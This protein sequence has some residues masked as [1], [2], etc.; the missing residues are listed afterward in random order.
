M[1]YKLILAPLLRFFLVTFNVYDT[2]IVV[3]QTSSITCSVWLHL[4]LGF[5]QQLVVLLFTQ[6]NSQQ[7]YTRRN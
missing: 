2:K 5:T 6:S 3:V 4:K 1:V 7:D